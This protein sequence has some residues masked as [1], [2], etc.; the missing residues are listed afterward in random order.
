[1]KQIVLVAIDEDRLHI[2][3]L[4]P[5]GVLEIFGYDFVGQNDRWEDWAECASTE[6]MVGILLNILS[7]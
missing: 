5:D 4:T 7:A 6:D 3:K 1:M 2:T